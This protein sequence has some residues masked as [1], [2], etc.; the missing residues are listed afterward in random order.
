MGSIQFYLS[1]TRIVL[2]CVMEKVLK[3]ALI[4]LNLSK[5][6]V[7]LVLKKYPLP[8]HHL[9]LKTLLPAT[10]LCSVMKV[11]QKLQLIADRASSTWQ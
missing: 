8:P 1:D 3:E 5:V 9:L 6:A 11:L 4:G 7:A 10:Y 2:Q